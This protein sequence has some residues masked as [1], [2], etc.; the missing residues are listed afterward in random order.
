MPKAP[1]AA[2]S[3]RGFRPFADVRDLGGL[4]QRTG[5]ALPVADIERLTVRYENFFALWC[6]TCA[7][8]VLPMCW[9]SAAPR[10]C[11]A[12]RWRRC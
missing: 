11:A 5:F 7:P 8:M 12:T 3:V 1:P 2:E 6:A 4:L 10:P 9:R